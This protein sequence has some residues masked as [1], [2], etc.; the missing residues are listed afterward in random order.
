[1]TRRSDAGLAGKVSLVLMVV[2]VMSLGFAAAVSATPDAP[3]FF[4]HCFY[5]TV[6]TDQGVSL[7]GKLVTARAW[8]GSWS[9]SESELADSLS[10]YGYT[11]DFCIPQDLGAGSGARIGDQIAFYVLGVQA[12]LVDVKTGVES[13]TYTFNPEAAFGGTELNLIVDK[14]YTIQASAGEHGSISPAGDVRVDYGLDQTF[15]FTP[16]YNYLILDVLVD[17]VSNPAAVA[18][19]QYTFEDVM[20]DHTIHVTFVRANY[21]FTVNAG[22]GLHHPWP[23][24]DRGLQGEHHVQHCCQHRL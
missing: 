10:R 17:G 6:K 7:A 13:M 16:D 18:A 19:G 8:T 15:T 1:M 20:E 2:L 21:Y 14:E 3:E 5:G 9:G 22:S 4:S 23:D 12:R 24:G 11:P